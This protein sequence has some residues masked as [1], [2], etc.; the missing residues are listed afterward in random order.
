M[1]YAT[2]PLEK[3]RAWDRNPRTAEPEDLAR[4]KAQI[5]KL[6]LYK[7]LVAFKENGGYTVLGGNMR[8]QVLRELGFREVVLSVV[9]PRDEAEKL[10]ISLADNDRAGYYEEQELAELLWEHREALE[11]DLYRVDTGIDS[12]LGWVIETLG[13]KVE[14]TLAYPMK[15]PPG[16]GPVVCPNCGAVV[17]E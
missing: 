15:N 13:G 1:T 9:K 12:A 11:H 2:A 4:L 5:S 16:S 14:E 17:D 8:L 7:P 10:E 3:V 6:K